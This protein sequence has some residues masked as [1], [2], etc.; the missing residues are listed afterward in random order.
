MPSVKEEG[1]H[2]SAD[3]AGIDILAPSLCYRYCSRV[4]ENVHIEPSPEWMQ[5]RLRD[6]G[7]RT[8]NNIVDITNYVCLE[9]GQPMHAFDLDYL[10][11]RHIIV[12]TA[13]DQE[14]VRTLDG[15]D[16]VLNDSMLVIADEQKVCAIAGVM[17]GEHSEVKPDTKAILFESATFDA[18][19]VRQTA[20]KNGLRTEASSRY[21]KGLDPDN[22]LR[23]LNRA[24]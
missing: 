19:S 11:G 22:A 18:Y 5:S 3:L 20:V 9:L 7:V 1:S 14:K 23:A 24:C 8:I 16:R 6:A 10:S 13:G 12:R 15:V 2:A 17:G 21:E 4:I